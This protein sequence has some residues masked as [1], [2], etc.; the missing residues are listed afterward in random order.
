VK[1]LLN[2]NQFVEFHQTIEAQIDLGIDGVEALPFT[3]HVL[4]SFCEANPQ[5][6]SCMDFCDLNPWHDDCIDQCI[7]DPWSPECLCETLPSHP[8]CAG[9]K[10]QVPGDGD[11][12][13]NDDNGDS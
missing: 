9:D 8:D 7:F 11:N 2:R 5:D 13:D 10:P 12:G 3:V 4:L 6:P 1:L